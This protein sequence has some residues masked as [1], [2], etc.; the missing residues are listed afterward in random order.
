MPSPQ[1]VILAAGKAERMKSALPKVF[2]PIAGIPAICHLLR[3]L[4]EADLKDVV[5]VTSPLRKKDLESLIKQENLSLRISFAIQK[6][7]KGTGHALLASK[8]RWAK[9]VKPVLVMNGDV[10]LL[11]AS[12]LLEMVDTHQN[13]D[14]SCSV[15]T[16]SLANPT[17]YG[18]IIRNHAGDVI[19]IVEEQDASPNEREN[20]EVNTGL[21]VFNSKDLAGSL[22]RIKPSNKKGEIYLTDV[23]ERL[24]EDNKRVEAHQFMDGEEFW[25]MN[26]REEYAE[27]CR[28]MQLRI[29][30]KHMKE[31]V[32]ILAPDQAWID[33][34]VN[35][36]PD[37]VVYPGVHLSGTTQIERNVTIEPGCIIKDSHLKK[38]CLIKAGSYI[39]ESEVGVEAQI[40]P[41]AHLRPESQVGKRAKVGNF[42]ELK[43]TKLGDGSKAN[44]LTY[45]GDA[46]IGRETNIG[47]GV[48][49]CNY[50]GGLRYKGKATSRVGD[51]AFVGSDVQL[52]A[53]VTVKD[54]GYVASGSTIT[55]DVPSY[56][57]AIARGKQVN[58]KDFIKRLKKRKP[59]KK[60]R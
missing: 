10:P 38:G 16:T 49:T 19:K 11:N 32:S 53:P 58:K 17:G 28:S 47:A 26:N 46:V 45:L 8:S 41:Y 55:D 2:F 3:T 22:S 57:L 33:V 24:V 29:N 21:Y 50:D 37:V 54:H 35:I 13:N 31:G 12:T 40:G 60:G 27:L 52:V 59:K 48:I 42:V 56:S 15:A 6:D 9:G 39:E 4:N 5:I 51:H 1:V 43:K 18:R 30:E 7:P 44:H 23:V 36:A 14:A 25:G 20:P 34:D